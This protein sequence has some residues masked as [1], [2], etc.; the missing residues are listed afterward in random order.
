[1]AAN[2]PGFVDRF[3]DEIDGTGLHGPDS[4]RDIAM[5][6]YDDNRQAYAEFAEPRQ[7]FQA[8]HPRHLHIQQYAPR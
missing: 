6:G 1:M 7:A 5:A 4:G 8:V 2:N 3:L